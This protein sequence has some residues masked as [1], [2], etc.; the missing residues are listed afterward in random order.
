MRVRCA[1][2]APLALNVELELEGF[3]TLLGCSGSGKT[4]LLKAIAGLLPARTEPWDGRPPQRRSVGY[5]PQGYALFPHLRAWQNAAFALHGPRAQRRR[6]AVELLERMGLKGL[7]ARYPKELSGG[8]QQRVALARALAHEPQLLLLDEPTSA[9][10]AGTRA[11]LLQALIGLVHAEG[12]P[13]L[14]ATHDPRTAGLADRVAVIT[15]GCVVQQG[16][17][18]EVFVR[19][20]SVAVARLVGIRN[21]F[22]AVVLG[23]TDETVRLDYAG[24]H[25]RAAAPGWLGRQAAV[26]VAIRSEALFP[27]HD[28]K[29]FPA[30]ITALHTEGL[31]C[32]AIVRAGSASLEVLMPPSAY[33]RRVGDAIHLNVAPE[34]VHV[35]P[36]SAVATGDGGRHQGGSPSDGPLRKNP[37]MTP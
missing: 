6:R 10:D 15:D 32:R 35:L 37:P 3:T 26:D 25:L 1:M 23:R 33:A 27:A 34:H 2:E 14:A 12:V 11:E 29:G 22:R 17:P 9:L 31:Q 28:G 19:P 18:G 4:T 7:E 30:R 21:F 36:A 24:L 13:A 20:A 16:E 8:Q 5:L